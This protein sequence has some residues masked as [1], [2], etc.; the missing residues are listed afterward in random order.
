MDT[1]KYEA[2][3]NRMIRLKDMERFTSLSLNEQYLEIN[4]YWK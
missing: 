1:W 4:N 3:L 2:Y